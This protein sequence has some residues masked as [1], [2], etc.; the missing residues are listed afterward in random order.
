MSDICFH[1]S[2]Y[3]RAIKKVNLIVLIPMHNIRTLQ[4]K[5]IIPEHEVR[6]EK[7]YKFMFYH[8]IPYFTIVLQTSYSLYSQLMEQ[9]IH[10]LIIFV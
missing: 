3:P 2:P 7:K 6:L 10:Y 9:Q 1:V 8:I 5:H 4:K